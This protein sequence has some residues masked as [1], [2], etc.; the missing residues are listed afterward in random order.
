MVRRIRDME[1]TLRPPRKYAPFRGTVRYVS[2]AMHQKR[3]VGFGDDLIGWF[4]A[5]IELLNGGLPW[6]SLEKISDIL[7]SKLETPIKDLCD[8][9][10]KGLLTFA[11]NVMD[12]SYEQKPKYDSL[13]KIL[14]SCL[15]KDVT[16]ATPYDWEVNTQMVSKRVM[17]RSIM[18]SVGTELPPP[19]DYPPPKK[20][21]TPSLPRRQKVPSPSP[22][23]KEQQPPTKIS[24]PS[25]PQQTV[26]VDMEKI[27]VKTKSVMVKRN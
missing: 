16:D 11:Q 20:N 14:R 15:R 27:P 17:E 3:D 6:S 7:K 22:M 1:G 13:Q 4:Y 21:R 5:M 10:P 18:A 12:I 25:D 23:P 19:I 9:H 2:I 8:S 26:D 24:L